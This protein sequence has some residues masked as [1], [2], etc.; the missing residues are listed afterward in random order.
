[1]IILHLDQPHHSQYLFVDYQL[2]I[3]I[4][5][6]SFGTEIEAFTMVNFLICLNVLIICIT[7]AISHLN[8]IIPYKPQIWYTR[9]FYPGSSVYAYALHLC[10]YN[11]QPQF[12]TS[13]I[14]VNADDTQLF[15]SMSST[16]YIYDYRQFKKL[17]PSSNCL[18]FNADK[19]E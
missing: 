17:W 4:L 1:M 10:F 3:Y 14:C 5:N 16:T 18:S 12:V 7:A 13:T 19:I 11:V 15:I 6:S 2:V 8:N 9:R